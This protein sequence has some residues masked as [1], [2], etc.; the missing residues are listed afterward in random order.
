M[1]A[2]AA[3]AVD[4]AAV[5]SLILSGGDRIPA[6]GLGTFG[7]DRFSLEKISAIAGLPALASDHDFQRRVRLVLLDEAIVNRD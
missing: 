6:V 3:G 1:N 2:S 4:P 5:P 7:S